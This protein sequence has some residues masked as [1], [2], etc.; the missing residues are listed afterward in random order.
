MYAT[1][2]TIVCSRREVIVLSWEWDQ[3]VPMQTAALTSTS[4]HGAIPRYCGGSVAMAFVQTVDS[5]AVAMLGQRDRNGWGV[6]VG[7]TEATM[8]CSRWEVV[9]LA[10]EAISTEGVRVGTTMGLFVRVGRVPPEP[11]DVDEESNGLIAIS[12]LV[13]K[14]W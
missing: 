9:A 5:A 6:V 13:G 12:Q 4:D 8:V 7:V 1:R 3:V 2:A 10:E 14:F 11:T